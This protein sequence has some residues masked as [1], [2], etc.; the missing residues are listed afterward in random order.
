MG[1]QTPKAAGS[2]P[3]TLRPTEH[4][5]AVRPA[6]ERK[7]TASTSS[8]H[9]SLTSREAPPTEDRH[10]VGHDKR[11]REQYAVR[12]TRSPSI[13]S[14]PTPDVPEQLAELIMTMIPGP[15]GDEL[16]EAFREG[17]DLPPITRQSLAELDIQNIITN[18]K[19]RHDVNF[20]RDLSFRPNLD[21]AKG[22]EKVKAAQRY[23][24]ALVAELELYTRLFRGTPPLQEMDA[25]SWSTIIQ[26][27]ERRIPKIFSTIRDVLKSLVPDRDHSRVDE[28]LDVPMLMQEIERGVCDLVRLSEWM[29]CLLKEHCA[30]MRDEWVDKMV[31]YTRTGV[32]HNKSESIVKG[33][34]ELLGILESMKLDVANHQIRNLK[35]LLI[36]DTVNFETHYHLD[37]LVAGR[38]RINIQT[39]QKWYGSANEEFSLSCTQQEVSRRHLEVFV[40]GVTATLFGKDGRSEFPET[41]YLDTDRLQIIKA[42]IEDY[43]FFEVCLDMFT[44][45]LKQFG[46]QGLSSSTTRK[47]LVLSLT[48][49]M[50]S[51]SVGHGPHQWMANSEALS[52]E[53]LRQASILACRSTTYDFD[54]LSSANQRLRHLF[55]STFTTRARNLEATIL[56]MVLATMEKHKNSSPMELFSNLVP[57]TASPTLP[58]T[59]AS[60]ASTTDT[61]SPSI[62]LHPDVRK[63]SD[64]ANRICHIIILHW[65]VW[66]K[67]AYVQDETAASR[68]MTAHGTQVADSQIPSSMRTGEVT[69]CETENHASHKTSSQ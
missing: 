58:S 26:H 61:L 18:I 29:A 16:A 51:T 49:I 10:Y 9:G 43:V 57:N 12:S 36:E 3:S 65:R 35:T 47:Q 1:I 19:L 56:P 62:L 60:S 28:H 55:F 52:L 7:R 46:C 13:S 23:W 42:E 2:N 6:V 66:G 20:D 53:I 22:Q 67:I 25:T 38:A 63:L 31:S 68:S 44:T 5:Y 50:G 69:D 64:I 11:R 27:A 21:G 17:S 24:R 30:P 40:R 15:E 34:C 8:W 14:P 37:R 4:A 54:N 33:L 48:A 45:L 32:T 39:A 59:Q 41:L